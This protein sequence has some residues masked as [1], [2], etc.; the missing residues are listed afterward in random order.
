VWG[1]CSCHKEAGQHYHGIPTASL[2]ILPT[3]QPGNSRSH[4]HTHADICHTP[5]HCNMHSIQT[6]RRRSLVT[7][8]RAASMRY[9]G[10]TNLQ[11]HSQYMGHCRGCW[12]THSVVARLA[13]VQTEPQQHETMCAKH[14]SSGLEVER[15][16]QKCIAAPYT[17]LTRVYLYTP[18]TNGA[19][20]RGSTPSLPDASLAGWGLEGPT[21]RCPPAHSLQPRV[22]YGRTSYTTAA[23][24]ARG[25]D[26][27]PWH[28]AHIAF[29]V[30]DTRTRTH[31]HSQA[32]AAQAH[33]ACVTCTT[34][35][36]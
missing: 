36:L 13:G 1:P 16:T 18:A 8:H 25:A 9:Q 3:Y 20:G 11:T 2:P 27:E 30:R 32:A 7:C 4:R 6:R 5:T 33:T 17:P 35:R 23:A 28:T 12:C 26:A 15:P 21:R 10:G 24:A 29:A 34:E 19:A 31:A 14:R 22:S